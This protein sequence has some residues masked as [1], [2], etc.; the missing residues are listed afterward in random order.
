MK[1]VRSRLSPLA[2][3]LPLLATLAACSSP[4]SWPARLTLSPAGQADFPLNAGPT[5]AWALRSNGWLKAVPTHGI[6]PAEVRLTA[7]GQTLPDQPL[8][9][10][11]LNILGDVPGRM[12]VRWPLVH[13][14]GQLLPPPARVQGPA[15]AAAFLAESQPARSSGEIIVKYRPAVGLSPQSLAQIQGLQTMS[16]D[17][18][19]RIVVLKTQTPAQSLARLRADPNVVWAEANGTVHALGVPAA[20]TDQYYPL[21]WY[22]RLTGSAWAYLGTYPDPVTVAVIDTGVRYDHPDLKGRLWGNY[23]ALANGNQGAL[24]LVARNCPV[25]TDCPDPYGLDQPQDPGDL[26]NPASGSHGTQVTGIITASSGNFTPACSGC[27]DSGIAGEAWPAEVKVL[28]IRVIDTGGSGDFAAVAA[29][30]RYAAGLPIQWNHQTLTNPHP[31]KVIN[32][33]LGGQ[34]F[35]NDMCDAVQQAV[36]RGVA[37][38]AAAGNAGKSTYFYPASCPGA[39]A[40]AATNYNKG[41]LPEPAWYTEHNNRISLSA[42]GGNTAQFTNGMVCSTGPCPD[43]IL[44][45]TW[46]YLTGKPNYGFYMGTSQAASQAS[47]AL[48]LIIAEGKAQS[49]EAA[50]AILKRHL[51][52][53]GAPGFDPYYGYGFLNLPAALGLKLPPGP[54]LLNV[55]GT[56]QRILHPDASGRFSTYLPAGPYTLSSCRD[57]SQNGL[58]DRDEPQVVRTLQVPSAASFDI[59]KIQLTRP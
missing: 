46:D 27:T 57:Q 21:Q 14:F 8:L 55:R 17:T 49:G 9:T 39:I 10:T 40:V 2:L 50:W 25:S 19:S 45:T 38:V 29:A 12:I 34:Q 3:L 53:L 44:S 13:V 54:Y 18:Y 37:V 11:V 51:T 4:P 36:N 52:D 41:G 33:S 23:P 59:G 6:G 48:A 32:L 20:S 15:A 31:A 47:A 16:V 26:A 24:N 35:S 7:Q 22:L 5:T 28:P 30:I 58:C 43:G 56:T 42:P 1:I